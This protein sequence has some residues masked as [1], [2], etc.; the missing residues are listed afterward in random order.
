VNKNKEIAKQIS[1][2][3]VDYSGKLNDS[4]IL[5]KEHCNTEEFERYRDAVSYIL[6]D[7]GSRVMYHLYLENPELKPE[8]FYMPRLKP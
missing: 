6:A 7:M 4:L 3:M 5:V 8:G 1:A 2:L